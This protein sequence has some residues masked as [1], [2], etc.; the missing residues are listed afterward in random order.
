[1]L[2]AYSAEAG[3]S[4]ILVDEPLSDVTR[5]G[6]VFS[7]NQAP[8]AQVDPMRTRKIGLELYVATPRHAESASSSMPQLLPVWRRH[9]IVK[10]QKNKGKWYVT[11]LT[12]EVAKRFGIPEAT[13]LYSELDALADGNAD[14]EE[15]KFYL[16]E[17]VF[18][19]LENLPLGYKHMLGR[20]YVAEIVAH[21]G[22]T[23]RIVSDE[24]SLLRTLWAN[25]GIERPIYEYLNEDGVGLATAGQSLLLAHLDRRIALADAVR[26]GL[27]NGN[28]S[29]VELAE[30]ADY[31]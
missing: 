28:A 6:G 13:F 3:I 25:L 2:V 24:P 27:A 29:L 12:P 31:E 16:N 19:M 5:N 26:S 9:W 7:F 22:R 20:A 10:V 30:E 23:A 14:Y 17:K 4:R 1:M 8:S 21:L 18:T 15:V 11:S